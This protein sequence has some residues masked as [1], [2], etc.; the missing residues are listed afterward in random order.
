MVGRASRPRPDAVRLPYEL[1]LALRYLRFHRGRK[2][3]SVI[4]LFSLAGVS[5][6]TAAMVIA[7]SLM[8]GFV[9]DVLDRIYSGSA[10]LSVLSLEADTFD[11]AESLIDTLHGVPGVETAS[12]VL[13]TPALV[14]VPGTTGQGFAEL[15]GIDPG[16][17]GRVIFG[18]DEQAASPYESLVRPGHKPG[19]LL[20]AELARK[21]GARVGDRVR[22]LVPKVTLTPF[23]AMPKSRTYEVVGTYRSDHF[24]EDATRAYLDVEE[25][26]SLLKAPAGSSWVEVRVDELRRLDALK[27]RIRAS[28]ASEWYVVDLVEQNEAL[29]KALKTERLILLLAIGLIVVVAALNIVSTLIL[30]VND[31]VR[32]IGTLTAMGARAGGIAK[33]FVLQGLVIGLS[34][35]VSGLILGTVAS[36]ALDR[37]ELIRVNPEVY[38]FEFVP[39]ATQPTDLVVVGVGALAISLA[40][41]L[42]PAFKAARLDPVE[43]IRYE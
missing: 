30:M 1:F 20:G 25:A 42:Y 5:V 19:I 8:A 14:T 36:W 22:V 10:H 26:R 39:F 40:A 2:F 23:S 27:E 4:T 37:Y 24:Q 21:I 31:K 7:L 43:A 15:H 28:I 32:E 41:T 29:L 3:L 13:F 12:P 38:Y 17:H 16:G 9:Q 35:G 33:V 6:G 18:A 34:G 11:G